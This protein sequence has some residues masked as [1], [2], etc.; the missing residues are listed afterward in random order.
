MCEVS[1]GGIISSLGGIW[2]AACRRPGHPAR[3]GVGVELV[4]GEAGDVGFAGFR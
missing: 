3:A 2:L 1:M 4:P